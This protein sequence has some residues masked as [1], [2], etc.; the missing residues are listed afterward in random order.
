MKYYFRGVEFETDSKYY[1]LNPRATSG[2]LD[3]DGVV[4]IYSSEIKVA[5][6]TSRLPDVKFR[7]NGLELRLKSLDSPSLTIIKSDLFINSELIEDNYSTLVSLSSRDED[8]RIGDLLSRST[9]FEVLSGSC[10]SYLLLAN[11]NPK[12]GEEFN[13]SSPII[14]DEDTRSRYSLDFA[15]TLSQVFDYFE[16]YLKSEFEFHPYT[17]SVE[18]KRIDTAIFKYDQYAKDIYNRLYPQY[19]NEATQYELP[20]QLILRTAS[21]AKF[22]RILSEIISLK[23]ITNQ[24]RVAVKDDLDNSWNVAFRWDPEHQTSS[25]EDNKDQDSRVSY[26]I[27]L[28]ATMIFY[29]VRSRKF[30]VISSIISRIHDKD[31]IK[32]HVINVRKS[33]SKI[34]S[35]RISRRRT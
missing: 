34:Q 16:N 21:A 18:Y 11:S 4:S 9:N 15:G 31:K 3:E 17:E 28:S 8:S 13:G 7:Y 14:K 20:F 19:S 12:D 23:Y 35:H 2:V 22:S 26:E 6:P 33:T 29:I 24:M 1:R 32:E 10:T 5:Q 25:P 30:E 27:S